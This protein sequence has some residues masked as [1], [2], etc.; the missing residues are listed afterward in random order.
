VLP[1][2]SAQHLLTFVTGASCFALDTWTKSLARQHLSLN[3]S[4]P[5]LPHLIKLTLVLNSGAAFGLGKNNGFLIAILATLVFCWL[6]FWYLKHFN[7]KE[8]SDNQQYGFV[9][10]LSFGIILGA[11]FG[12]LFDRC[13]HGKVTDFLEFEFIDFP[14]FNLADVFIDLGIAL[15][16]LSMFTRQNRTDKA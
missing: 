14:V 3:I 4:Q 1:R 12:N 11:A 5:F 13:L 10:Q 2:A 6:F 7:K 16:I 9:E 15:M 8:N